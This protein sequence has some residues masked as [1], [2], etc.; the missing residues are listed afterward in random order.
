MLGHP[1]KISS[2]PD[3]LLEDFRK[4]WQHILTGW[5]IE[6][7][8]SQ[9]KLTQLEYYAKFASA[10]A[11]EYPNVVKLINVL[12][13]TPPNTS[14][15]ERSYSYLELICQKRRG[16]LTAGHLVPCGRTADYI[17]YVQYLI[18]K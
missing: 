16:S 9:G 12:L 11:T 8:K 10:D 18:N 6:S 4:A 17:P 15:L 2:Q 5:L 7:H 3:E 14:P 1:A 13:A